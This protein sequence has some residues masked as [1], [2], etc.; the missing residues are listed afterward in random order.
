MKWSPPNVSLLEQIG[1][2]D[3]ANDDVE[4]KCRQLCELFA[5]H[6][7][8][9][10]M[11]SGYYAQEA[12]RG[13]FM[14]DDANTCPRTTKGEASHIRW[15]DLENPPL[16]GIEAGLRQQFLNEWVKIPI[17]HHSEYV[18]NTYNGDVTLFHGT[19]AKCAKLIM[20]IGFLPGPNG[21]VKNRKI[22]KARSWRCVSIKRATAAI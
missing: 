21:H 2:H 6:L 11:K 7:E 4:T 12:L 14:M 1:R 19:I 5:P 17:E 18:D 16:D 20:E 15:R 9:F 3:F 10:G 13:F 22:T 8:A